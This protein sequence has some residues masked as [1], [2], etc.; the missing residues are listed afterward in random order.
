MLPRGYRWISPL[1][2]GFFVLRFSTVV[3][4][5][6]QHECAHQES[7]ARRQQAVSVRSETTYLLMTSLPPK[8]KAAATD[9]RNPSLLVMAAWLPSL[10]PPMMTK[11]S[12]RTM[13]GV[14][15]GNKQA[16]SLVEEEDGQTHCEEGAQGIYGG[17]TGRADHADGGVV[18][19]PSQGVAHHCQHEKPDIGYGCKFPHL[20]E[21]EDE[22]ESG[23][24]DCSGANGKG[25]GDRG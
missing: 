3:A 19:E 17:G 12:P 2:P 14:P 16:G 6:S 4:H 10:V 9:R 5:H 23:G 18:E 8:L 24:D 1:F 7:E 11:T 25:C 20:G 15:K 22:G 13:T 21:V